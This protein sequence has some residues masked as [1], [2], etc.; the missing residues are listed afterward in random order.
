LGDADS[1]FAWLD[2]STWRWP[3]RAVRDDPALD[4]LRADPRFARLVLRVAREMG[5]Q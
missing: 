3:N 4:P 2:K 5:M 1:A